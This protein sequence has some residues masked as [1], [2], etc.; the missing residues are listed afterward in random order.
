MPTLAA[1]NKRKGPCVRGFTLLELLVV[2]AIV[3]IASTGA[4][5]ALRD[6]AQA[7]LETQA[8]RLAALLE[9]GRAQS[10]A[11]GMAVR[12]NTTAK[13]FVLDGKDQVWQ[14][15]G[16]QAH[17]EQPLL[18]GPEPIIAP[19][20]VTLWLGEQPERRLRVA[21]DGVRPFEVSDVAR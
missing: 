14:I 5:L 16:M 2:V 8:Q 17:T 1:G 19:Q 21:T 4:A 3:A 9:T 15:P 10:R 20:S 13:G 11:S 6:S 12:W 7:G 18:L